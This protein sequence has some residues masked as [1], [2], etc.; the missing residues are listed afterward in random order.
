MSPAAHAAGDRGGDLEQRV[1]AGEVTVIVV[2]L[3]EVVGVD[4]QQRAAVR[5]AARPLDRGKEASRG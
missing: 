2:D 4:D 5:L 3:L 1:V